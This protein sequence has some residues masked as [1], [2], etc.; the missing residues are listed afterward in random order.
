MSNADRVFQ[1]LDELRARVTM[2]SPDPT[3]NDWLRELTRSVCEI[4][5]MVDDL[6]ADVERG[7]DPRLLSGQ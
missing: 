4:Q 3:A 5:V 1:K 2:R 6:K 7:P